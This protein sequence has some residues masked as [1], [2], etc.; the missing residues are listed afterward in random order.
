MRDTYL[1]L[2]GLMSK[3]VC[4]YETSTLKFFTGP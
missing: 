4:L 3:V 1:G 2:K